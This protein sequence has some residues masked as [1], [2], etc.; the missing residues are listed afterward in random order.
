MVFS[1]SSLPTIT[2]KDGSTF[3]VQR[4]GLSS[5]DVNGISQMYPATDGG[6][7]T[8]T[9]QDGQYYIIDGLRVYR[10][11]DLWYYYSSTGWRRVVNQNGSWYYA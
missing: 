11:N 6:G 1:T 2:K 9:Y 4:N 7:G 3:S 5:N 10:Y 8:P